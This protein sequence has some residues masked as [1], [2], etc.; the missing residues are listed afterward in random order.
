MS[1]HHCLF[2]VQPEL[3]AFPSI[4][5]PEFEPIRY[6]GDPEP[7]HPAAAELAFD[8]AYTLA[9]QGEPSRRPRPGPGRTPE[10]LLAHWRGTRAGTKARQVDQARELGRELGRISELSEP[11]GGL[12][13]DEAKA[14]REG[15]AEGQ[16]DL[17][18]EAQAEHWASE[19]EEARHRAGL[20]HEI[21]D[22]DVYPLGC[23]S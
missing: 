10:I 9:R 11:P 15:F 23:V 2:G 13:R 3:P 12:D 17:R 21:A 14:Y 18:D 19:G 16:E 8:L 6:D 7:F 5:A 4:D 20:S 1:L 22:V